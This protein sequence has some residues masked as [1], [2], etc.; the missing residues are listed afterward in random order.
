MLSTY[1]FIYR[2]LNSTLQ[3]LVVL[4]WFTVSHCFWVSF[5]GDSVL[6]LTRYT[7]IKDLSDFGSPAIV[8]PLLHCYSQ[9][10]VSCPA[11]TAIGISGWPSGRAGISSPNDKP[12]M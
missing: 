9:Q 12:Y 3:S 8:M 1:K 4:L 10:H 6:G 11:V 7:L 2:I 5:D